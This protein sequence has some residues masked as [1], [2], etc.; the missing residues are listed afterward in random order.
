MAEKIIYKYPI[1][2]FGIGDFTIKFPFG[3]KVVHVDV[4][5]KDEKPYIWVEFAQED[6]D[7]LKE[8]DFRIAGTGHPFGTGKN[9]KPVGSFQQPP[10]VW[11]VYQL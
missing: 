11:H 10:F 3:G 9:T 1:P 7:D 4:D 5:K 8:H 6:K 2:I